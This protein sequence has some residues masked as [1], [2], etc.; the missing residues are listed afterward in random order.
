MPESPITAEFFTDPL[1]VRSWANQPLV[2]K[3]RYDFEEV[4][5]VPRLVNLFPDTTDPDAFQEGIDDRSDLDEFWASALRSTG[6]PLDGN[7]WSS[8]PPDSSTPLCET[9]AVARERSPE[10]ACAVLWRLHQRAFTE[11]SV[12]TDH[13]GL[14]RLAERAT[15]SLRG[16]PID[17]ETVRTRLEAGDGRELLETDLERGR[18]VVDELRARGESTGDLLPLAPRTRNPLPDAGDDGGPTADP[19]RDEEVV[20]VGT[21]RESPGSEDA[22]GRND[23][24]NVPGEGDDDQDTPPVPSVPQPPSVWV[25][26]GETGVLATPED[27]EHALPSAARRFDRTAGDTANDPE[28]EA[29]KTMSGY[30]AD[31]E[32]VELMASENFEKKVLAYLE[33]FG[34][35]FVPELTASVEITGETCERTLR[36]LHD[37]GAVVY[38][39]SGAWRLR[40]E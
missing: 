6:M 10:S 18:E 36:E 28:A 7:L 38:L 12:P 13:E 20:D 21:D 17:A 32:V 23:G 27:G 35:A 5:W 15:R 31:P 9:V 26:Q 11:G 4:R 16:R 39:S 30:V 33:Y 3:F 22:D 34:E 8:D 2:R 29:T 1:S 24:R 14:A 25:S 40:P 37:D 19:G